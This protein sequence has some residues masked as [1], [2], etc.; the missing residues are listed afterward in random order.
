MF[1]HEA[2]KEAME[3]KCYIKRNAAWYS[4]EVKFLPT[5]T[6]ECIIVY[7]ETNPP[8]RRWQPNAEDL[9]ADDWELAD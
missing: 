8:R 5:N 7:S 4:K 3:K 2:V 1:I 6:P 9:I